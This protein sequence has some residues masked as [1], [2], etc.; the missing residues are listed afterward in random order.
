MVAGSH[1]D[2]STELPIHIVGYIHDEKRMAAL[3]AAVDA[4]VTPSLQ[5]NLP[6]TIAEAMSCGTPCVGFHVGGIPEMIHHKVDGYVAR[7][8]DAEDLAEGIRHVLAHPELGEAAAQYAHE[9]YNGHRIAQ[10]YLNEY[11]T[12]H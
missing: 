7:F 4:F 11:G 10:L 2:I 6:N 12:S 1:A 9:T 8:R 3:Y 5:E